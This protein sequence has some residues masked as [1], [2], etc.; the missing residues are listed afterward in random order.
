MSE[1]ILI[2]VLVVGGGAAGLFA[3]HALRR[4]GASVL[5]VLAAA[6]GLIALCDIH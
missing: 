4:A 6:R 5:S 3:L 1:P 2:D